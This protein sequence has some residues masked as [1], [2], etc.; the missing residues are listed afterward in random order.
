[1]VVTIGNKTFKNQTLSKKYVLDILAELGYGKVY[2]DN[3][4]FNFLIDLIN[5]HIDSENKIGCG[6]DYFLIEMNPYTRNSYHVS[7][8]RKDSTIEAFSWDLCSKGSKK[9]GK[10]SLTML[11]IAMRSSIYNDISKFRNS[12]FING[13]WVCKKCGMTSNDSNIIHVDH[14]KP[15]FSKLAEIFIGENPNYPTTFLSSETER[16]I[17]PDKDYEIKWIEYHNKNATFQ[18]LCKLC[19]TEKSN[20]IED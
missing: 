9:K 17:F 19:N 12:Q 14:Y 13:M 11:K 1:M 18:M 3:K 4:H 16:Y 20:K 15:S 5:N 8:V 7:I 10:N 2:N 6:I